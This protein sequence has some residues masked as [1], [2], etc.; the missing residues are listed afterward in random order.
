M[1]ERKHV[2]K[3]TTM[4]FVDKPLT[5]HYVGELGEKM[6][7][8]ALARLSQVSSVD[9]VTVALGVEKLDMTRKRGS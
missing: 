5:K 1:T 9:P 4:V 6:A 2:Y 3:Y 8:L 7:D